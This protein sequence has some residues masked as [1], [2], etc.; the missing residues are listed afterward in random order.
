M[1]KYIVIA[2]LAAISCGRQQQTGK[3]NSGDTAAQD[4]SSMQTDNVTHT[5]Y[6]MEMVDNVKDPVCKMP[7]KAGISD[8]A[9]YK[10]KVYG[11]CAEGCKSEFEAHKEQYA[12]SA[13]MKTDP[14]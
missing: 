3:E 13:K 9:H 14:S 7:L 6:S 11:F 10:S 1:K 12:A 2:L 8:T 4:A 5:M